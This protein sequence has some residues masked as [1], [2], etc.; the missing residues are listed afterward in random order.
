MIEITHTHT[1][2]EMHISR[3]EQLNIYKMLDEMQ[4][5]ESIDA[6]RSPKKDTE[7]YKENE[8]KNITTANQNKTATIQ[9]KPKK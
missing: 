7:I 6:K 5:N 2:I 4:T 1:H 3:I 9:R 8:K